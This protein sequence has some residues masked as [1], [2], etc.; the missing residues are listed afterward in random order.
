M[1]STISVGAIQVGGVTVT[2]LTP[3]LSISAP[4]LSPGASVTKSGSGVYVR[5]QASL[6]TPEEAGHPLAGAA[7]FFRKALADAPAGEVKPEEPKK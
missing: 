5:D 6:P 7:A 1:E 4:I 3:T 2:S